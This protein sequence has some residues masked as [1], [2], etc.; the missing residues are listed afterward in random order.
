MLP[1]TCLDSTGSN[2][3]CFFGLSSSRVDITF[4]CSS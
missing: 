2:D 1:I 4:L 3:F